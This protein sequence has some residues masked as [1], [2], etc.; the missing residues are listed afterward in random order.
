[1]VGG[2]SSGGGGV[3]C[4]PCRCGEDARV[5]TVV[6]GVVVNVNGTA[7]A[8]ANA[9]VVFVVLTTVVTAA[10]AAAAA[11]PL[12]PLSLL[13]DCCLIEVLKCLGVD[14]IKGLAESPPERRK[15]DEQRGQHQQ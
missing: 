5:V 6:A 7:I 13:V 4:C 8:V 2:G 11:Q 12:L 9:I 14:V 3:D 1:L 15:R 10:I